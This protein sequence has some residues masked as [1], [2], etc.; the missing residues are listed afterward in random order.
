MSGLGDMLV[1]ETSGGSA[2]SGFGAALGAATLCATGLVGG[3]VH[4]E[5][6]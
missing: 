6:E 5:D 4:G 2:D 1:C 3:N